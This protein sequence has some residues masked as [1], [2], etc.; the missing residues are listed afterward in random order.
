MKKKSL[1][2]QEVLFYMYF[3]IMLCTKGFGLAGGRVYK[4]ALVISV[5]LVLIKLFLDDLNVFQMIIAVVLLAIGLIDMITA[6]NQGVL[7]CVTAVL[8][9]KGIDLKHAFSFAFKCWG[10]VFIIQVIYH[11]LNLRSTDFVIHNKPILGYVIRWSLG[12][13]HPNVLMIAFCTLVF[14]YYYSHEETTP[15]Q[16]KITFL[17]TM[18]GALYVFVYS[19]SNTGMILLMSFYLFLGYFEYN[20]RHLRQTTNIEKILLRMVFPMAVLLSVVVP[21]MFEGEALYQFSRI[22]THRPRL[23]RFFIENYGVS[24]FGRSFDELASTITLDCSYVNLLEYGG[25]IIFV[26]MIFSY[27]FLIDYLLKNK[28]SRTNSVALAITFCVVVAAMSEPFAFNTSFKN[29]SLFFIGEMLYIKTACFDKHKCLCVNDYVRKLSLRKLEIIDIHELINKHI[30]DK[31]DINEKSK[32]MNAKR[33]VISLGVFM[34]CG[35]ISATIGLSL[36]NMP[37]KIYALRSS[38][39]TDTNPTSLFFDEDEVQK[40]KN[41]GDWFLNY[42]DDNTPVLVFGGMTV[43]YER[44]RIGLSAFIFGGGIGLFLAYLTIICKKRKQRIISNDK[45]MEKT[46]V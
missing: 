9:V 32:G 41:D 42:S 40:I 2:L 27:I 21:F 46:E 30:T 20:R 18:A 24:W 35:L 34:I 16:N 25:V 44:I 36:V 39:D 29:P 14:Y 33:C 37:D 12:Y 4:C 10:I 28:A 19:I 31:T 23:S 38:C 5:L 3:V 15:H 11:L 13:V 43:T 17:C 45:Y 26:L 8:S 1:T 6:G 22:F 7:V